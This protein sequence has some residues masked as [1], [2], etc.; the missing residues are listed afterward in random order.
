[1]LRRLRQDVPDLVVA[2]VF[3]QASAAPQCDWQ[4]PCSRGSGSSETGGAS[5]GI[6]FWL[7][8]LKYPSS[9]GKKIKL[10]CIMKNGGPKT[11]NAVE[12]FEV[13]LGRGHIEG[14]AAEPNFLRPGGFE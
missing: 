10:K 5:Q 4:R 7:S 9:D 14:W 3:P 2:E 1:M 6:I 8:G 11:Q 13:S 12:T